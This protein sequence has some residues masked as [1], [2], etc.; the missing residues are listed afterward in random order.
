MDQSIPRDLPHNID[1]EAAVLGAAIIHEEL[2]HELISNLNAGDF[3]MGNHQAIYKA[4]TGLVTEGK[5]VSMVTVAQKSKVS[6]AEIAQIANQHVIPAQ[7]QAHCDIVKENATRRRIIMF[8]M[9]A[10]HAA[11]RNEKLEDVMSAV[12]NDWFEITKDESA[13]WEM[14][15]DLL[16]RHMQTV[17]SRSDSGGVTGVSTGFVDLDRV[18]LGWQPGQLIFLGATPKMGKTSMGLHFTLHSKVPTLFFTLEMLPEEIADRQLSARTKIQG[19]KIR[20]GKFSDSDWSTMVKAGN[21]LS[22]LP[23]GWVKKS[24]MSVTEIRAVCRRFQAEKGLGLVVID[25]LDKIREKRMS[26]ESKTDMIGRITYGL[27]AMARDLQVPVVVLVQLLDKQ[28]AKRGNPRPTFGDIRDSSCPD[29][30]GDV[31]LFLWRPEFYWPDKA[32]FRNKAEIIVS[33]Q[34]AGP[35]GSVWVLWQPEYTSFLNLA[36]EYWPR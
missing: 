19:Q 34:R 23:I 28:T 14:N 7:F 22:K 6:A 33:R 11:T 31:V 17:Q 4:I 27:K 1:A 13:D 24:G 5:P 18:T 16:V 2:P 20:S 8:G 9:K 29:Q 21:E 25:Q 36:R 35:P 15:R 30:D 32:Q 10:Q 26:N 12:E 3:Y